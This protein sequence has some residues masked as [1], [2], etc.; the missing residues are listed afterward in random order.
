MEEAETFSTDA[1]DPLKRY[2]YEHRQNIVSRIFR[3]SKEEE[4]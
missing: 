2:S 1:F 3:M 4:E